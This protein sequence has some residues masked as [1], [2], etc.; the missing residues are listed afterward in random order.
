VPLVGGL[1]TISI[2][3]FHGPAQAGGGPAR[4]SKGRVLAYLQQKS[5]LGTSRPSDEVEGLRFEVKW[6]PTKGALGVIL[7]PSELVLS[8]D[9]QSIVSRRYRLELRWWFMVNDQDADDL[10]FESLLRRVIERHT[11]VMLNFFQFQLQHGPTRTVFSPPGAI[12][13][14]TSSA[15]LS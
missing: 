1:L 10:D 14:I 2:V 9:E 8:V 5:K 6:E 3:E 13:L 12:T 7:P 11:K 15:S 4:S